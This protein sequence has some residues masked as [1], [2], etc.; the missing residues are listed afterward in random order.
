MLYVTKKDWYTKRDRLILIANDMTEVH[1]EFSAILGKW[2]LAKHFSHDPLAAY[3]KESYWGLTA[4]EHCYVITD[5]KG[6]RYS[7]SYCKGIFDKLGKTGKNYIFRYWYGGISHYRG[8]R[9]P[10]T[11]QERRHS[12]GVIIDELE[13]PMR[14]ARNHHNLIHAWDDPRYSDY[15]DKNWKRH[16]KTQWK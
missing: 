12:A 10:K 5:N 15:K 9:K 6:L 11:S 4:P 13:P 16:R 1:K 8:G 7:Q 3:A 2:N 14:A